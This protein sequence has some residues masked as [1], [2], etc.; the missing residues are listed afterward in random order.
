MELD[1]FGADYGVPLIKAANKSDFPGQVRRVNDLLTRGRAKVMI[2]SKLEEDYQKA[3]FDA[4]ARKRGQWRWSS[5]WHPDPSE[6]ARYALQAYFDA[7][8]EPE[9]VDPHIALRERIQRRFQETPIW[10]RTGVA[11]ADADEESPW[12]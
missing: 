1:T 6:A 5:Q 4:D 2:G 9:V 12:E 8:R 10:E 7:Y 3:R 11:I